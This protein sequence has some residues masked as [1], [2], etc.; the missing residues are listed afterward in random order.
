V[1]P[2]KCPHCGSHD[3][4]VV[5][6]GCDITGATLEES[7]AWNTDSGMY[8]TGGSVLLDA[9]EIEN[10]EGH[11]ICAACERDVSKEL[12]DYEA[13]QGPGHA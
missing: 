7:F 10:E 5:L 13:S 11:A 9:E 1:Q 3:Y 12:A 2:F 8:D 6:K 4:V